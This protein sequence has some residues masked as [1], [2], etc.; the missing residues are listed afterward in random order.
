[1]PGLAFPERVALLV[2]VLA[3]FALVDRL[4]RGPAA[5]RWRAYGL[6]LVGAT[7]GGLFGALNDQ[8]S[9]TLSRAYFVLGK[10][11]HGG[12]GLRLEAAALGFQAGFGAGAVLCGVLLATV[13]PPYGNVLPAVPGI[14]LG[15]TVGALAGAL[16]VPL[17]L[18]AVAADPLGAVET[19]GARRGALFHAAWGEHAGA[20]LGALVQAIRAVVTNRSRER[21]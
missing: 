15:A 1:M 20:Y 8:L 19:L 9:L 2:V 7:A 5:T 13:K 14:L 6:L 3:L 18:G 10:G 11:L 4:H 12:P 17:A 16:I 21:P